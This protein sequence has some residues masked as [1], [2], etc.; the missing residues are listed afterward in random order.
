MGKINFV[1]HLDDVRQASMV[2]LRDAKRMLSDFSALA[3]D[4]DDLYGADD[5]PRVHQPWLEDIEQ[6]MESFELEFSEI[7]KQL[8]DLKLMVSAC[9]GRGRV[10]EIEADWPR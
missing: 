4:D 3:D 10:W 5:R 7:G 6:Q 9:I 1:L 2:G 8:G